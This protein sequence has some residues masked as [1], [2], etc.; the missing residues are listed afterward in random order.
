[1]SIFTADKLAAHLRARG[2]N[3]LSETRGKVFAVHGDRKISAGFDPASG[4]FQVGYSLQGSV[5]A[6][7]HKDLKS[8]IDALELPILERAS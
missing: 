5:L 7:R 8:L 1:M 3:V 6:G 4:R 2:A